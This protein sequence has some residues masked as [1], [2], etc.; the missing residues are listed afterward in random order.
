MPSDN[1]INFKIVA[2]VIKLVCFIVN[3]SGSKFQKFICHLQIIVFS[4]FETKTHFDGS[5]IYVHL[6]EY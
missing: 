3:D 2:K 5:C 1:E 6:T 4:N